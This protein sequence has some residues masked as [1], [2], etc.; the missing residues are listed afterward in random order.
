MLGSSVAKAVR[1]ALFSSHEGDL[2]FTA[3]LR[4]PL[5]STGLL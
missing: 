2:F 5:F 4:V 3:I 1:K